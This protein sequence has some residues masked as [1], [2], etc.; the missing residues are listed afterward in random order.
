V[1]IARIRV[2]DKNGRTTERFYA[3]QVI[4][5][6]KLAGFSGLRGNIGLKNN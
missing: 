1:E 5:A 3:W 2:S 6:Q 4:E